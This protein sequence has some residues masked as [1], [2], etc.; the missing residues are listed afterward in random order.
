VVHN[1]LNLLNIPLQNIEIQSTVATLPYL[2]VLNY[3]VNG[4][5]LA[6]FGQIHPKILKQFDCKKELYYAEFELNTLYQ[7]ALAK[8]VCFTPLAQYPEVERDL[9]LI[10]DKQLNY[11]I[12][13]DIAC[14]YGSKLLKKVTLFDVYEGAPL[15]ETQKSY[16]LKF[17]LQH[18]EKTLTDEEINKVMDKLIAAFEKEAGAKL[19]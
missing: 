9:A 1:I 4:V 17:I 11:K 15:A 2:N 16:A 10:V 8:S 5:C 19:R 14:K 18:T 13:E 6:T 7:Q 3:T 12:L